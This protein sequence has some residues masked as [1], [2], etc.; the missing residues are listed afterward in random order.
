MIKINDYELFIFDLD[1]T[2]INTEYIHYISWK[3]ILNID[4][5]MNFYISKFHS[6]EKDSIKNYLINELNLENLN[7]LIEQK[8]QFYINYINSNKNQISM[9]DGAELLL[10]YIISNNK[11]FYNT[12]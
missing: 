6:K 1:D 10:E 12:K 9:I 2:L 5:D 4:F 7:D 11:E 8:N 3:T